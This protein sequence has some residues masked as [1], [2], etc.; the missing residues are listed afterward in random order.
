MPTFQLYKGRVKVGEVVGPDVSTLEQL[1]KSHVGTSGTL[2][3]TTK[4]YVLGTGKRV[5]TT[6]GVIDSLKSPDL[7]TIFW[8][9]AA[10]L[11]FYWMYKSGAGDD[12]VELSD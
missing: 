5:G 1:I 9:L 6:A 7:K 3:G 10:V 11:L 4:G 8:I 12:H 2:N